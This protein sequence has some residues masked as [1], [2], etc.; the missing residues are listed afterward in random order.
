MSKTREERAALVAAHLFASMGVPIFVAPQAMT[1]GQWDPAGGT[2]GTGYWL[3]KGW[4]NTPPGNA[5]VNAWRPGLALAMVMGVV[6]DGLDVDPRNDGKKS[7]KSMRNMWPKSLARQSTPSGGFHD[8]IATL[9]VASRDAIAPGVDFKGGKP[10]GT[11]RGFLF[12][13]PTVKLSKTDGELR[14]YSWL[15]LTLF[16][17]PT[18]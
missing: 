11:G 9:G 16:E 7:A 8:L 13:A 3:P 5:G 15:H 10:D 4:Q 12:V 18:E 2:G 1:G 17:E 14:A 6:V